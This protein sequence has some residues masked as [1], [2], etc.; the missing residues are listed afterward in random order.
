MTGDSQIAWE[1][2]TQT[3]QKVGDTYQATELHSA[4]FFRPDSDVGVNNARSSI[5]GLLLFGLG[6]TPPNVLGVLNPNPIRPFDRQ[7]L[8]SVSFCDVKFDQ[9]SGRFTTNWLHPN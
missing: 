8:K 7:I 2:D 6:V 4:V 1:I 9:A 3:G 5:S